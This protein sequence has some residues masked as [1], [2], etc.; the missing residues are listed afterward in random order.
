MIDLPPIPH[1]AIN[2]ARE[3]LI[4]V[5]PVD[6]DRLFANWTLLAAHPHIVIATLRWAAGNLRGETYAAQDL[7]WLADDFAKDYIK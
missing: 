2:E 6:C 7:Q 1:A 5:V 4:G 3:V